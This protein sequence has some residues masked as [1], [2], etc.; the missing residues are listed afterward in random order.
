MREVHT[1][2]LSD[3]KTV[4]NSTSDNEQYYKLLKNVGCHIIGSVELA[5][6]VI[7][8]SYATITWLSE[9]NS[10][11]KPF[12]ELSENKQVEIS[13]ELEKFFNE[14]REK[15]GTLR[16]SSVDFA[17]Q[18]IQIPTKNS[19]LVN[20]ESNYIVIVNWG[21]LEDSFDRKEGVIPQMFLDRPRS[22]ILVR[23]VNQKN[24]PVAG[25]NLKLESKKERE[26]A[27]TDH[28]GFARFGMLS[29]G[30]KFSIYNASH[31][32]DQLL[33][34]FV[35]DDR[36][37]YDIQIKERV[38]INLHF[39]DAVGND[40]QVESYTVFTKEHGSVKFNTH[41][42]GQYAFSAQV[43]S[44]TFK[45]Y[46]DQNNKIFEAEIPDTDRTF[47]IVL[48]PKEPIP[49]TAPIEPPSE[50]LNESQNDPKGRDYR[51]QF[52]NSLGR[53][54]RGMPVRFEGKD[55]IVH[56]ETTD[57]KGEIRLN[58]IEDT[59]LK[60]S[61]HRYNKDWNQ[62]IDIKDGDYHIIKVKP[63]FPWLWWILL[64]IL[65]L[66]LICCLFF[67]CF[68][69]NKNHHEPNATT[70]ERLSHYERERLESVEMT[71]CDAR[72]ESG[73]EGITNNKHYLGKTGGIV[74]I[75]YDMHN[76]PDKL[77]IFYE[78]E[79]VA[80][81][82]EIPYNIDGF[83]GGANQAGCCGS[84][85]FVYE[86]NEEEYCIVR[87]TGPNDTVWEYEMSCPRAF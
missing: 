65:T 43:I 38:K 45:V 20:G 41:K 13:L 72:N 34:S 18:L 46:D 29:R 80:S 74:R 79:R 10:S 44:D 57:N 63:I 14:F 73:G 16:S 82:Y 28:S 42:F 37:Q 47:E 23:L 8:K 81:T 12:N 53:S 9:T 36:Q 86:P 75:D 33:S 61:F 25:R 83:I 54:I 2:K 32:E 76:V 87:I 64:L 58:D 21:F 68:C 48:E 30:D 11:L 59:Q 24:N 26:F 71:P 52:V 78:G 50:P 84:L 62:T 27:D 19:I 5:R 55:N 70:V 39:K 31:P 66:L 7:R 77:E 40:L 17:N 1:S 6:P 35:C 69:E 60:F 51:F 56:V 4:F 49:L 85:E 15:I 67:N 3:I 22:S